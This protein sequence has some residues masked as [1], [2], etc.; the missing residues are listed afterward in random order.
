MP[1]SDDAARNRSAVL[2]AARAVFAELGPDAPVDEVARRAGVGVGTIYRNFPGKDA[3]VLAV[4]EDVTDTTTAW[5]EEALAD[6]DSWHGFESLVWRIAEAWA[7]DRRLVE[8]ARRHPDR[9]TNPHL[10]RLMSSLDAVIERA[11]LA[12]PIDGED[13]ATLLLLA[14]AGDRWRHY[15]AIVLDGL[16]VP[17]DDIS[18]TRR[19]GRGRRG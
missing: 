15:V 8:L 10:A 7:Q 6:P 11:R 14:G 1:S 5:A 16:R 19:G 17:A 12:H 4:L 3:L 13:L 2:D 18:R 9:S